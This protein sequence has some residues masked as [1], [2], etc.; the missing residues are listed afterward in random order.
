LVALKPFV[1]EADIANLPL[2]SARQDYAIFSLSLMGTNYI[3]FVVEATRILKPGGILMIAEV[4]SRSPDWTQFSEMIDSLG[5]ASSGRTLS[6]YFRVLMFTRLNTET[7]SKKIINKQYSN[8]GKTLLEISQEL[9]KP[10][11]Y[12]KR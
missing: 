5:Y 12:K 2:K 8:S 10:C 1:I 3:E 6:K 4:E 9:L 7:L 11:I